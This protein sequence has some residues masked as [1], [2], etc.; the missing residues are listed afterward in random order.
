MLVKTYMLAARGSVSI[1]G[2]IKYCMI[3]NIHLWTLNG[4]VFVRFGKFYISF[5]DVLYLQLEQVVTNLILN[6]VQ[7]IQCMQDFVNV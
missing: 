3:K 7:I 1:V 5:Y 2:M 4:N 6:F